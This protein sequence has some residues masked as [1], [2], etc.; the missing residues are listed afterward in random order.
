MPTYN[1]SVV[2]LYTI[3]AETEELAEEY[4]LTERMPDPEDDGEFYSIQPDHKEIHT[5]DCVG[6]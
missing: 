2:S 5:T 3:E 6:S 4:A 1:I